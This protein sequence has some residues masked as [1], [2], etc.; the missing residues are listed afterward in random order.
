[1]LSLSENVKYVIWGTGIQAA[2]FSYANRKTLDIEFYIDNAVEENEWSFLGKKVLR[3]DEAESYGLEDYFIILAVT[4]NTY[5]VIKE[6]LCRAGYN[7]FEKFAWYQFFF[8]KIVLLH[9]NCHMAIIKRFLLSS[10]EFF[11]RY[12]IYPLPAIQNI[13]DKYIS[14]R[15]LGNCDLY[16][17]ED[18]RPDNEFGFE[19][20]DEYILPRLKDECAKITIP[21]LFGMGQAFF[22]QAAGNEYN[23]AIR[24]NK[25]KNGIFP[26]GDIVIDNAVE[27]GKSVEEILSL[28]EG[29]PFSEE[30]IQNSFRLCMSKIQ[31]RE[32][33]WDISIYDFI[34]MNYRKKKL[35]FDP[36]HPTNVVMKEIALG[37]LKKLEIKDE[38]ISCK[39][40]MN[41][42]EEFVYDIV[43]RALQLEW[44]DIEI[45]KGANGKKLGTRMTRE[46][47][48]KEYLF[49]C[50]GI[51][52]DETD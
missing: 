22:P 12:A 6:Q 7:E 30:N 45:R 42:H 25:D 38:E 44:R 52:G 43:R 48:V 29:G 5:A 35:F 18:I 1:M 15:V 33:N 41:S 24:G 13:Q 14:K 32:K 16:I 31:K 20:S 10:K 11:D 51:E 50:Y 49:W 17:H 4:E 8:K 21:N 19:L 23:P 3:Y 26:Y 36:G 40:E 37:I 2:Q 27:K 28:I 46:E 47:Y 34:N 39:E 9:G